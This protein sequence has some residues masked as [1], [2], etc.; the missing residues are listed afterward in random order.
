MT[1]VMKRRRFAND[2]HRYTSL[3]NDIALQQVYIF[4]RAA[5]LD[6]R[7]TT[8][9]VSFALVVWL[10]LTAVMVVRYLSIG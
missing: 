2:V 5:R 6:Q 1:S 10:A 3:S 9:K 8:M 7:T 4:I